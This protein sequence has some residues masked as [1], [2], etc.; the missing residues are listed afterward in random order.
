LGASADL[1]RLAH[2]LAVDEV[3][4]A[5]THQHSISDEA[6]AALL[7]CREQGFRVTTMPALFERLLGRVPVEHVGRDLS[8]VLP[9]DEGGATERLYWLV[10]RLVDIVTALAGLVVLGLVVPLVALAN[11]LTSAGPLFYRQARVGLAGRDFTVIKFRTMRPDAEH[12]S[13]PVWSSEN[14]PRITAAGRWLRRSRLDELPQV[15]NVLRGEMSAIGP[16]PER[17]EFV[18]RLAH[19]IPFYRARHAV[20]PGL[21]GWAQVRYGYGSSVQDA[22]TKLEYD[23]YY[24]RHASFYLDAM[25]ALKTVAVVLKLQGK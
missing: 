22:L 18:D 15:L 21:T 11:A 14:D 2:E 16:R 13:G 19:E 3:V 25:I 8:A 23:L 17:P 1:P 12:A 6:F 9:I 4:L 7:A 10:K 24:V 20:K 5:I